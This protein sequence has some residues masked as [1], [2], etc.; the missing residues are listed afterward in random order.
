MRRAS[1]L[2]RRASSSSFATMLL[3]RFTLQLLQLHS[4]GGGL[5]AGRFWSYR[6]SVDCSLCLFRSFTTALFSGFTLSL[7]CGL[8]FSFCCA[9]RLACSSSASR[10]TCSSAHALRLLFRGGRWPLADRFTKVRFLRTSICADLLFTGARGIFRVLRVLRCSD[11]VYRDETASRFRCASKSVFSCADTESSADFPGY[12]HQ[13]TAVP[14]RSTET[15]LSLCGQRF[16]VTSVMLFL[17][18]TVYCASS[19]NRQII[20]AAIINTGFSSVNRLRY[21][22]RNHQCHG[23][24]GSSAY[25]HHEPP[26]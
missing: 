26:V 11:Q 24:A 19:P 9:S 15:W 18:A 7:F 22:A 16:R 10:R 2:L 13:Q 20:R 21:Q 17:P 3:L 23:S 14:G 6:R 1:T 25:K 8:A 5:S 12:L 4:H